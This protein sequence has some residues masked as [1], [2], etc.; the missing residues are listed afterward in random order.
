MDLG[1]LLFSLHLIA[2]ASFQRLKL[3]PPIGQDPF[4]A[5]ASS[6]RGALFERY[7][8]QRM[9][10]F[11]C[12]FEPFFFSWSVLNENSN[13]V[14]DISYFLKYPEFPLSLVQNPLHPC[15]RSCERSWDF[16]TWLWNLHSWFFEIWVCSGLFSIFAKEISTLDPF[17]MCFAYIFSGTDRQA[18]NCSYFC[19]ISGLRLQF[20]CE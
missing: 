12:A 8:A 11:S 10:H 3:R 13:S 6:K 14:T 4:F 16:Q 1:D 9:G 18:V 17:N 20:R 2:L 5:F 15:S 7:R 19:C